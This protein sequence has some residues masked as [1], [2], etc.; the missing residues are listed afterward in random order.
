ML[1]GQCRTTSSEHIVVGRVRFYVEPF[2]LTDKAVRGGNLFQKPVLT[3]DV[4]RGAAATS[5]GATRPSLAASGESSATGNPQSKIK[6]TGAKLAIQIHDG[7]RKRRM[8]LTDKS[9]RPLTAASGI[10]RVSCLKLNPAE[11]SYVRA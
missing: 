11:S 10:R 9:T 3:S 5:R 4:M 7:D 8:L 2:S 6:P 1:G